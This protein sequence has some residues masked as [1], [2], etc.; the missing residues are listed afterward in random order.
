MTAG[1]A[2]VSGLAIVCVTLIILAWM[3][4]SKK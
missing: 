1:T 3:G 4:N 2:L